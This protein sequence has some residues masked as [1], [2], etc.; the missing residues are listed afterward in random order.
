MRTL[1]LKE[2]HENQTAYNLSVAFKLTLCMFINTAIVPVLVNIASNRWFVTGGL[3]SNI[4]SIMIIISFIGP[5]TTIFNVGA[6]LKILKQKYYKM[7]GL[8]TC[9]LT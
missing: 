3:V 7:K 4:F 2:K 5:I 1:S 8:E 9:F 6:L